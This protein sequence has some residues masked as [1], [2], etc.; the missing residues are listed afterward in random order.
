MTYR[1]QHFFVI[2]FSIIIIAII[3]PMR[4]VYF[5][6]PGSPLEAHQLFQTLPTLPD[7]DTYQEITPWQQ[8][9]PKQMRTIKD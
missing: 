8:K 7:I 4:V 2:I 3:S 5:P 1:N 6:G 9:D